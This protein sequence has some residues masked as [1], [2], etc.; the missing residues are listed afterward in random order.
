MTISKVKRK[1]EK[2][3][4]KWNKCISYKRDEEENSHTSQKFWPISPPPPRNFH[5]P[6]VGK[7]GMDIFWN[8]TFLKGE[9]NN[10][11]TTSFA[12]HEGNLIFFKLKAI[13]V[14]RQTIHARGGGGG[15]LKYNLSGY[16]PPG[17]PK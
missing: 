10:Q 3:I 5:R 7:G 9:Q 17:S 16:V 13:S 12:R 6:S 11:F 1:F 15:L 14:L 4:K 8:H 2:P